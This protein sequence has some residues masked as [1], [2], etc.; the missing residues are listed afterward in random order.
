MQAISRA[1]PAADRF[2]NG[3]RPARSSWHP[4]LLCHASDAGVVR[5]RS[6]VITCVVLA[7][8][9]AVAVSPPLATACAIAHRRAGVGTSV[10]GLIGV[11][12]P[13]EA[14]L[15]VFWVKL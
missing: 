2:F 14:V 8:S 5:L 3:G 15:G 10:Y 6:L 4:D 11:P 1:R 12:E 9:S 7:S 13:R